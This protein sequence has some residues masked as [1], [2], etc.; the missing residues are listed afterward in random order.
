M[1]ASWI[2]HREWD[3][4][5]C[6]R[7]NGKD[8]SALERNRNTKYILQDTIQAGATY[9]TLVNE[10]KNINEVHTVLSRYPSSGKTHLIKKT[11]NEIKF[12]SISENFNVLETIELLDKIIAENE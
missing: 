1:Q 3:K 11:W 5:I 9:K 2:E 8:I 12:I 10:S 7:A 6:I 4:N